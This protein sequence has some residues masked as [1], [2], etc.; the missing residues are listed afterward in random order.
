MLSQKQ[1]LNIAKAIGI[2]LIVAGHSFVEESNSNI[3]SFVYLFHVPFFFIISGYFYNDKYTESPLSLV[4]K[5][6]KTLWWP[7][8]YWS[9]ILILLHNAFYTLHICGDVVFRGSIVQYVNYDFVD[10]LKRILRLFVF[11]GSE[12]LLGAF[13]FLPCLF[14]SVLTF[15]FYNIIAL[16]LGRRYLL[17]TLCCF[18][19]VIGNFLIYKNIYIPLIPYNIRL[20]LITTFLYYLGYLYRKNESKVIFDYRLA[21]VSLVLLA[22]IDH[23]YGFKIDSISSVTGKFIPALLYLIF[24]PILG[25]YLVLYLSKK[26]EFT[27]A[28]SIFNSIGKKTISILALHFLSFKLVNFIIVE[29]YDLDRSIV[30]S[31]PVIKGYENWFLVYVVVGVCLPICIHKMFIK[32]RNL[33]STVLRQQTIFQ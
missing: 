2:V 20:Y 33:L 27:S 24:T 19:F 6:I 23:Y 21:L 4:V 15:L 3:R 30:R 1:Y 7:F 18:G 29:I 28:S 16:K 5:R 22:L 25:T 10:I 32:T 12:Q 17:P 31:F 11:K 9:I 13:W 26:L 14:F 8:C